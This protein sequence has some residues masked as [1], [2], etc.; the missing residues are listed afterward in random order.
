MISLNILVI[1]ENGCRIEFFIEQLG[2]YNLRVTESAYDAI[3][4][5]EEE[6]YDII[7]LNN[8]LGSNNG[9]GSDIAAYLYEHQ[10]NPNYHSTVFIHSW[11]LPAIYE[12][13]DK[14]PQ[15]IPIPYGTVEFYEEVL[16][17]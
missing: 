11:Y 15:A 8:Y 3:N 2:K 13:K 4:Y 9:Y 12:I 14:L 6:V 16:D 7:F 10:N 5:L 1:E 17:I